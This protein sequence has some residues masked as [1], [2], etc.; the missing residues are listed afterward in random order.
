MIVAAGAG[1]R[2]AEQ[3]VSDHIELFVDVVGVVFEDLRRFARA[4]VGTLTRQ[5]HASG[6]HLLAA[7][8]EVAGR[9]EVARE[10]LGDELIVGFVRVVSV[11]D[12]V[13][14]FP[15]Q[16]VHEIARFNDGLGIVDDVEPVPR[17][18]FAKMMAVEQLVDQR[19]VS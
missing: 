17:P 18:A 14:V 15:D 6:D 13:A 12:V 4:A 3:G 19:C 5:K 7:L 10:L 16:R 8:R 11:D 9:K 2:E 1:N